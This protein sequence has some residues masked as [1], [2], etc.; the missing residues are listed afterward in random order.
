VR[1]FCPKQQ[2]TACSAAMLVLVLAL[3]LWE[4]ATAGTVSV[5]LA[6]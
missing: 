6:R 2:I 3:V 1:G 4:R 5:C